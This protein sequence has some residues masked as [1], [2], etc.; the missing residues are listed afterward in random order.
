MNDG[1]I[2]KYHLEDFIETILLCLL[3]TI[4]SNTTHV[5]F[6]SHFYLHICAF[7]IKVMMFSNLSVEINVYL[8]LMLNDMSLLFSY[9]SMSFKSV[10]RATI[11]LLLKKQKSSM[12]F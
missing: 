8:F 4:Q 10:K 7:F 5:Y 11:F 6:S 1:G 9:Y 2:L 3:L 12:L